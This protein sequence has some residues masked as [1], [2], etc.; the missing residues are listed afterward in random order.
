MQRHEIQS[1]S[2]CTCT[3]TFLLTWLH[4][5]THKRHL[6]MTDLVAAF[7]LYIFMLVLLCFFV[8]LPFLGE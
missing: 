2:I 8:L 4:M 3:S 5:L 6:L 1:L 7:V